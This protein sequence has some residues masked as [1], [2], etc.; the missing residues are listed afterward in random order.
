MQEH[1][2]KVQSQSLPTSLQRLRKSPAIACSRMPTTCCTDHVILKK[3]DHENFSRSQVEVI[4][5]HVSPALCSSQR[6][7][8]HPLRVLTCSARRQHLLRV[9]PAPKKEAFIMA[10]SHAQF[11]CFFFTTTASCRL[12]DDGTIDSLPVSYLRVHQC[13]ENILR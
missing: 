13:H 7:S 9:S 4:Q 5:L 2:Q 11:L 1:L 12:S 6:T 3:Q 8:C 10:E